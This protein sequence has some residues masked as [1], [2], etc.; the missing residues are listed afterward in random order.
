M[1]NI[2]TVTTNKGR[3]GEALEAKVNKAFDYCDPNGDGDGDGDD[4]GD[5]DNDDDKEEDDKDD[6]EDEDKNEDNDHYDK[7]IKEIMNNY[8]NKN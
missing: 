2:D 5:D 8:K 6:E 7:L 1:N 3:N 4:D